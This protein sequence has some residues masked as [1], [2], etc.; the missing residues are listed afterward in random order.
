[1]NHGKKKGACP[2]TSAKPDSK[3]KLPPN[4]PEQNLKQLSLEAEINFFEEAIKI[5]SNVPSIR[6]V[7]LKRIVQELKQTRPINTFGIKAGFSEL[8]KIMAQ[9]ISSNSESKDDSKIL[10]QNQPSKIEEEYKSKVETLNSKKTSSGNNN[11]FYEEKCIGEY[12]NCVKKTELGNNPQSISNSDDPNRETQKGDQSKYSEDRDSMKISSQMDTRESRSK[13]S[14]DM[15]NKRKSSVPLRN[16]G[17]TCFINSVLQMIAHLPIYPDKLG[18]DNLRSPLTTLINSMNRN[19]SST[20]EN[21]LRFLN[22]LHCNSDY[23]SGNQGDPKFLILLLFEKNLNLITWERQIEFSH[24][25][26]TVSHSVDFP[27][28]STR[29]FQLYVNQTSNFKKLFEDTLKNFFFETDNSLVKGYCNECRSDVKGYEKVKS[30][31]KANI[32]MFSFS[33]GGISIPLNEVES[34]MIEGDRYELFCII[35]RT[36]ASMSFGHNFCVCRE[37]EHTWVEYNDFIKRPLYSHEL[38]VNNC[39][40]LVYA[41]P[42]FEF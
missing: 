23:K 13:V 42:G 28:Q 26:A 37:S 15:K 10:S 40:I 22:V 35:Q 36:G 8:L 41:N 9:M 39:Y 17:N 20:E 4:N 19:D 12:S 18:K 32:L 16:K 6:L 1:M 30:P 3:A 11:K 25:N 34:L 27:K 29:F 14:S 24:Q 7:D 2:G 38:A 21:L 33:Q 5:Y 31:R